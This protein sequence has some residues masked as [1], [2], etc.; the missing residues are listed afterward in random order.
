MKAKYDKYNSKIT[1]NYG[2]ENEMFLNGDKFIEITKNWQKIYKNQNTYQGKIHSTH[3][4]K[5]FAKNYKINR[6]A[7]E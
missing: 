7:K 6:W 1:G 4:N 3:K 2:I 5:C